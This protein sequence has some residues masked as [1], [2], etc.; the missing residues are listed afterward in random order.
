MWMYAFLSDA[1]WW[2][3]TISKTPVDIDDTCTDNQIIRKLQMKQAAGDESHTQGTITT[4]CSS[5]QLENH[6]DNRARWLP[7]STIYKYT[8]LGQKYC[9]SHPS[10][11]LYATDQAQEP[12]SPDHTLA[13]PHLRMLK[14]FFLN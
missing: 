4:V 9:E 13:C 5:I 6:I 3:L 14:H 10:P 1:A 12:I 7:L 2:V 8:V 11:A